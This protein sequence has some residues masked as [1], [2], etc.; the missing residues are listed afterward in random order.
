MTMADD[1]AVDPRPHF[2]AAL[3][4]VQRQ[5]DAMRPG[6]FGR[7]T[8]CAD[9]DV[10]DLIA[11]LVAVLR[12]L[13]VV[14]N[15]GNMTQVPDPADDLTSD[16]TQALRQAR[17]DLERA[18]ASDAALHA[19]YTMAWGTMTGHQVLDAYTHEFTVHAWDLS[20]AVDGAGRLDPA[21]AEAALD[22]FSR[23]VP[24]E[25]RGKD[26]PFAEPVAVSDDADPYVKLAAYVGRSA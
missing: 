19:G 14:K 10:G 20:R 13:T 1:G 25:G 24:A 15:G 16:H 22:W 11:H 8:P 7:P 12:K 21:L 9:Y 2:A 4:Q 23:N 18:W 3:D 6:D 26:G 17:A 5:V